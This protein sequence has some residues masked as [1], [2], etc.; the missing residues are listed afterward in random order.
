[1]YKRLLKRFKFILRDDYEFNY[2]IIIDVLYL[3]DNLILQ[4]IDIVT[5]FQAV[6]FLKD[7]FIKIA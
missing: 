7:M 3:N 4:I 5:R 1:M 2:S 6:K